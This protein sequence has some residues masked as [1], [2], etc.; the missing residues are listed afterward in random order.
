MHLIG[1]EGMKFYGYH[2]YYE[3]ERKIGEWYV[4]DVYFKTDFEE[5]AQKDELSGT[6]NYEK[7]FSICQ[8]VMNVSAQLLEYLAQQIVSKI[9][10]LNA[11]IDWLKVRVKK[12]NPPM[13][14]NIG[15]VFVE[16][17]RFW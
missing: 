5:A 13:Q 2:G 12:L 9:Q 10:Q 6:I 3:E 11:P 16:I 8:E 7:V 1:L 14:G 17:E 15:N 4:V